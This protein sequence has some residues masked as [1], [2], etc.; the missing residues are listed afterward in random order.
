MSIAVGPLGRNSEARGAI[1][2]NGKVAAMFSYSK[3]RGL[4]GGVSVEGSVIVERQ[5]TNARAYQA[6]YT[7]KQLLDGGVY[8]PP[9]WTSELIKTLENCIGPQATPRPEQSRP[10]QLQPHTV[11]GIA[12]F[13]FQAIEVG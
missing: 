6:D 3:T 13:D 2:S 1:N 12:L 10:E 8:P 11:R 5:D 4:F 9:D 7:V